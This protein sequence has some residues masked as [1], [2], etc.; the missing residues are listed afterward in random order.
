MLNNLFRVSWK[1]KNAAD[2][3]C[4]MLTSINSLRQVKKSKKPLKIVN[5]EIINV[6]IFWTTLGISMK[7]SGK[8]WL[9]IRVSG[10]LYLSLSLSRKHSFVKTTVFLGLTLVKLLRKIIEQQQTCKWEIDCSIYK[11]T[12]INSLLTSPKMTYCEICFLIGF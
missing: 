3:I 4:Y 6:H 9:M 8:T 5:I 7:F 12:Y 1:W 11:K 10:F 2:I